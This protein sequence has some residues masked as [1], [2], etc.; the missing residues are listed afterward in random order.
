MTSPIVHPT[1]SADLRRLV[2]DINRRLD[3]KV[4]KTEFNLL[5]ATV[6]NHETRLTAGGL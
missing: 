3:A 1:E 2:E 4:D 5:K 6:E